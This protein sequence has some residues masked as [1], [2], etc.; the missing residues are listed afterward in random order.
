MAKTAAPQHQRW[1]TGNCPTGKRIY[2]DRAAGKAA[3]KLLQKRGQ[4]NMRPYQCTHCNG[5]WHIGHM[6]MR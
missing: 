2:V 3:A 5:M 4:G 6:R 1:V